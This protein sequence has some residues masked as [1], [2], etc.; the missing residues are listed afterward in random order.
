MKKVVLYSM[1][2]C[3]HCDAAKQFFS[4]QNITYR[5]CD[6]KTPNGQKEFRRLG[7]RGVPVIKVGDEFLNG[8]NAKQFLALYQ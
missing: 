4:K 5:L 7:F 3:V 6:V 1:K 2:N 8:F